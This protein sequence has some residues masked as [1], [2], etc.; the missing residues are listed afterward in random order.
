[1]KKAEK[2]R[3]KEIENLKK[4]VKELNE[5]IDKL[6]KVD[7]EEKAEK[8]KGEIE[9]PEVK[10]KKKSYK[11][12]LVFLIIVLLILDIFAWY[13]YYKPDIKLS[14][15]SFLKPKSDNTNQS[16]PGE[17]CADGTLYNTCSK[18]KPYFCYEGELLKKAA[19]C[20][21]PSGYKLGFQD[22]LKIGNSS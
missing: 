18:N 15:P 6:S 7:E 20:G 8:K 10:R 4:S 9:E 13:F 17:K 14:I 5:R 22:C 11:G 3:E 19:T 16:V 21:C 2:E 1:M 12:T